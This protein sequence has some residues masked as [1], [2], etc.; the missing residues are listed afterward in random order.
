MPMIKDSIA[1]LQLWIQFVAIPGLKDIVSSN[2]MINIT[3]SIIAAFIFWLFFSY[4]PEN[5]RTKSVRPKVESEIYDI[6]Q[7]MFF[8]FDS[9]MSDNSPCPPYYQSDISGGKLTKHDIHLGLQ[10]K[11]ANNSFLFDKE[12][13]DNLVV[14]GDEFH[15]KS[16]SIKKHITNLFQFNGYLKPDEILLLNAIQRELGTYDLA[17]MI[18][19]SSINGI[20]YRSANPSLAFMDE[21]ISHLYD[22]FLKLQPVI[23]SMDYC[24]RD[25]FLSRVQIYFYS[26]RYSEFSKEVSKHEAEFKSDSEL[27]NNYKM[28][29]KYNLDSK[30]ALPIIKKYIKQ[31]PDIIG[32]RDFIKSVN[33]KGELS[34]ILNDNY[35]KDELS[36]FNHII[37]Q[38]EEY[39]ERF[40]S[41]AE[42]LDAYYK[43][44]H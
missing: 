38:E 42:A 35:T 27:L 29:I 24:N 28:W 17:K 20:E 16:E 30:S 22:L 4:Y 26:E 6:Y 21:N 43:N 34:S 13:S 25:I 12:I 36:K 37:K 40:I 1:K 9:I 3:L 11:V 8:L 5:Q 23:N 31:K 32:N 41:K 7:D 33:K 44:N 10:N 39:K 14:F 2:A 18:G 19:K 15:Q